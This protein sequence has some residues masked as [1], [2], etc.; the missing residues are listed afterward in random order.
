[1]ADTLP[2]KWH[3]LQEV[4]K[5]GRKTNDSITREKLLTSILMINELLVRPISM[6]EVLNAIVAETQKIFD[7]HRVAIFMVN[8]EARLLERKYITG[9]SLEEVAKTMNSPLHLDK[10]LC[11]ETLVATSGQTLYIPDRFNDPRITPIDLKMDLFW[12]RLSTI[13]A[14]LRI[15]EDIIGVLEGDA[16][17]RLLHLSK[18]EIDLFAFFANQASIIIENARFQETNRKKIA[19]LLLLQEVTRKS[20]L[21]HDV[22]ALINNFAESALRLTD[23]KSCLVFMNE[24]DRKNMKYVGGSGVSVLENLEA[25]LGEGLVDR[26]SATGQSELIYDLRKESGFGTAGVMSQMASPIVTEE[27]VLGVISVYSDRIGAFSKSD[28]EILSILA[29]HAAVLFRNA[30]LYEQLSMEKDRAEN[31]LES[32]QNG[33][34][35]ING[36]GAIQSL[37]LRAEQILEVNR[38]GILGKPV[39]EI[40]SAGVEKILTIALQ[41]GFSHGS[42][43]AGFAKQSGEELILAIAISPLKQVAGVD[44]EWMISFRDVTDSKR[45]E[46][47]MRRLDRLSSLGQLSAGIAHEIRNPLSG[48]K[49]NLQMLSKKMQKDPESTEKIGDSLEG[50]NRINS[51]IKNVLNFA[52]PTA[53]KFKHDYLERVLIDTINIMDIRLKKKKISVS[54]DLPLTTPPVAFDENQMR[55][56]F[57]NL[58]LN[59]IDAMPQ[60]GTIEISGSMGDHG[61]DK[62][63]L[64]RLVIS[65]NGNGMRQ[66]FLRKIFDPF[67]TTKPEGTGLGLSIVHKILE[68]HRVLVEVGSSIGVGTVFK[69]TFPTEPA[70]A[71]YV[72]T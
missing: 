58:L 50:I 57:V 47:V 31:I 45:A 24:A 28:L 10:H 3:G 5:L 36:A 27:R 37:N 48:I 71:E 53:P 67:F 69:L 19:Q 1:M 25:V 64:F 32:S 20:S 23:A 40:G 65:D 14:P 41:K 62:A 12:K 44:A 60:G 26:V 61:L 46:E 18:K 68:Q 35:T 43:E 39:S 11:T 51:L 9:F 33:I 16:T 59:A 15:E 7:L 54:L 21:T 70:E 17:N 56:V 55:Q 49:L 30:A 63:G 52:R 8:K 6:D 66:E 22:D 72:P 34:I 38:Y 42:F 29:S 2:T 4:M 13:A